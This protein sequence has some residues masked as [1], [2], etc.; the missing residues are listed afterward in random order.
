MHTLTRESRVRMYVLMNVWPYTWAWRSASH[1]KLSGDCAKTSQ[2]D[3]AW[4]VAAELIVG[5]EPQVSSDG[6]CST[7]LPPT[8]FPLPPSIPTPVRYFHA[9]V[10]PCQRRRVRTPPGFLYNHAISFALLTAPINWPNRGTCFASSLSPQMILTFFLQIGLL[11][12]L[13]K[14]H[15]ELSILIFIARS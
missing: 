15:W 3:G 6:G 8:W 1:Y 4:T 9:H 13:I 2:Q 11:L 12:E 7:P 5:V 14:T 10:Y